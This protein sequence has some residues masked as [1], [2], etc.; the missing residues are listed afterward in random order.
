MTALPT[1]PVG[2]AL[3]T[4]LWLI[5]LLPIAAALVAYEVSTVRPPVYEASA[6]VSID[7]SQDASQGFDVAMQ[8][9]QSLS[10]RFITLG[11]SREVLRAVCSKERRGCTP[12]K[13]AKQVRVATPRATAQLEIL[14]DASSPSTAA[15]LANEA[16]DA[17]IARNRALVDQQSSAE[18]RYLQTQLQQLGAQLS[19]VQQQVSAAEAAKFPVAAGMAQLSFLQTEYASNYQRLQDLEV[20]RS[21][22]ADP[23]SGP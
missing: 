22:L 23:L 16:A 13:L 8:A 21:R 1:F 6:L 3:R 7:E 17:L 12:T 11:T 10:Q 15:R 18:L 5:L 4:K 2:R 19:Q 14:A 9:D 20:R